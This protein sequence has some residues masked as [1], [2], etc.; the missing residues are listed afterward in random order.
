LRQLLRLGLV[1]TESAET[2]EVLYRTTA[3]FLDVFRLRDLEDLPE[4]GEPK[5]VE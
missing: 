4:L 3:R 1:A 5:R 2:G